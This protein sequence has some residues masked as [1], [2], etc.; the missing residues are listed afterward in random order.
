MFVCAAG[1]GGLASASKKTKA[2]AAAATA[3]VVAC[4]PC[5]LCLSPLY[6][7]IFKPMGKCLSIACTPIGNLFTGAMESCGRQGLSHTHTMH[8]MCTR[9][10]HVQ[11][12]LCYLSLS[13]F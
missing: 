2:D 10:V 9:T 1:K 8:M 7:I 13:L 11:C 6:Y 3:L 4:G 12:P 5:L